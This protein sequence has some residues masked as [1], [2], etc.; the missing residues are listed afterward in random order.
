MEDVITIPGSNSEILVEEVEN[1][2]LDEAELYELKDH[3]IIQQEGEDQIYNEE[4]VVLSIPAE[5]TVNAEVEHLTVEDQISFVEGEV[6]DDDKT[7]INQV[8]TVYTY[9][10][11]EEG[12]TIV[13]PSSSQGNE[14]NMR[15]V[16]IRFPTSVDGES[17]NWLSLV[18]NT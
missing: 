3:V 13:I 9:N 12:E 2:Q 10:E 8:E 16:Q 18:Q 4:D 14:K 5:E 11:T 1:E 17:K 6:T 7:I 15:L